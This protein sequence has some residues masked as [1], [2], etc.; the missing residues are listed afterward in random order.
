MI[1]G[2]HLPSA[3]SLAGDLFL[4]TLGDRTGELLLN[5]QAVGVGLAGAMVGELVLLGNVAVRAGTLVT[6]PG[7]RLPEEPVCRKT[8][9]RLMLE[10]NTVDVHSWLQFFAQD[11]IEEVSGQ[12]AATGWIER[13]EQARRLRRANAVTYR[14]ADEKLS[15]S[16]R[17]PRLAQVLHGGAFETWHDVLL[18][19]LVHACGLGGHVLWVTG[20]HPGQEN[21]QHALKI[22]A[23]REPGLYELVCHVDALVG[24]AVLTPRT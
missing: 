4:I 7:S 3:L 12:L 16:W 6:V 5:A 15:A 19:G 24:D 22:I 14:P 11:S 8:L 2:A 13:Q 21:I 20:A 23:D 10:S 17:T 1:D 18:A 9:G